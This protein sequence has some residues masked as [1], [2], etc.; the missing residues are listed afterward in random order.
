M[1]VRRKFSEPQRHRSI[2]QIAIRSFVHAID[3]ESSLLK[4]NR[5]EVSRARVDALHFPA[6]IV[7]AAC[8]D[9]VRPEVESRFIGLAIQEV[10][11]V[12]PHK[13]RI[14]IERIQR[15][16]VCGSDKRF[17]GVNSVQRKRAAAGI[18]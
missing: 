1:R 14:R 2:R 3:F 15:R 11:I 8:R 5:Q 18:E 12:L 7:R 9:L 13:E 4:L 10:E 17:S 6:P 16:A